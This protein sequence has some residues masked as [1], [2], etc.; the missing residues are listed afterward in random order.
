MN[1][2]LIMPEATPTE[3]ANALID[4][5]ERDGQRMG[6]EERRLIVEY[7]EGRGQHGQGD[8]PYQ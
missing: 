3:R 6:N 5:A 4:W 8:C 7:A 1:N 2:K